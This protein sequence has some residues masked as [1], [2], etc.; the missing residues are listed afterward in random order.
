MK[1][2]EQRKAELLAT[3]WRNFPKLMGVSYLT[4]YPFFG[5]MQ[6]EL[7]ENILFRSGHFRQYTCYQRY[8]RTHWTDIISSQ[9]RVHTRSDP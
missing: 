9:R 1:T 3:I 6:K 2:I 7:W 5:R 4:S 8:T